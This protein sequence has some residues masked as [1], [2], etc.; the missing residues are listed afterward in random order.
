MIND[1]WSKIAYTINIFLGNNIGGGFKFVG[2]W[3]LKL[4][5]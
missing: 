4:G 3:Q 5:K 1:N 2:Y